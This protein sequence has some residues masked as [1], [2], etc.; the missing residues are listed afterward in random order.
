LNNNS[1]DN[2]EYLVCVV[3]LR[4]RLDCLLECIIP[5]YGYLAFCLKVE[6]QN[7]LEFVEIRDLVVKAQIG[8]R[9]VIKNTKRYL[10]GLIPCTKTKDVL[11]DLESSGFEHEVQ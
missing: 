11:L 9:V 6:G 7:A 10:K 4:K 8:K 3:L 5:A 2:D 1:D